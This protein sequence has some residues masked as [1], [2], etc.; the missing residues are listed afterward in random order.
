MAWE[1][2]VDQPLWQ[3]LIKK[4]FWLYF[5]M[6]FIAPAWYIVR[7]IVSNKLSVEDI[8]LF[9]SIIWFIGLISLYNDLWL[10]ETLQYYLPK[11]W[12]QKK[13]NNYKTIFYIT[14]VAQLISWIIIAWLIY[15]WANWLAVNHFHSP[16]ASNI[17][18]ILCFYFIWINFLQAFNSFYLWF[19]DTF[20]SNITDFFRIYAILAF[21]ILF[22]LTN[23]LT[24]TSFSIA[25]IT[26]LG[27]G[28]V[29]STIIFFKKYLH[30]LKKW[31]FIWDKDLIKTQFKYAFWIFLWANVWVLFGQVDQQLVVNFLGTESA[32]YYTNFW[33]LVIIYLTITWPILGILFPIVTELMTKN[34]LSKLKLLQNILYKYFSVFALSIGWIFFALWPQL[35]TIFFGVKFTYSGELLTYAAPFLII[36]MFISINYWILAW[37]GKVK[38]RVKVLWRWLLV[39]VIFN[40]LLILVFHM[41]L[42]WAVISMILW[43]IVLWLLSLKLINKNQI[44]NFDWKYFTMNL[45]IIILLTW[46]WIYF[47]NNFFMMDNT[48]RFSNIYYL[49][50]FL[51]IYYWIIMLFNYKSIKVLVQEVK[52]LKRS[53]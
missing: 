26:W 24:S 42:I 2:L 27:I 7:V 15:L 29:V 8:W 31:I 14:L 38:E 11:Y 3:K 5:F 1:L 35:A 18:R 45:G 28:L 30:T 49:F 20:S 52:I 48:H 51:I 10:T 9:Y 53:I 32:W 13:Y 21:T 17:I 25:W 19:Q 4:W 16:E 37:L 36:H 47:K 50:I 44:I 40:L 22:R 39:N 34:N 33:G 41:W 46:A 12:I 6:F 43:W 23:T